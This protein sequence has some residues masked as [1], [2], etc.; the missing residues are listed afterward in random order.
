MQQPRGRGRADHR[1]PR[2]PQRRRAGDP[3]PP[4]ALRRH[5]LPGRARRARRSRSAPAS[6]TSPTRSTRCSRRAST[7]PARPRDEALAELRRAAGTQFCPRCVAR[8]RADPAA[9]DAAS[10][11][12]E[13]PRWP[14]SP[15]LSATGYAA[16]CAFCSSLN[17]LYHCWH[18]RQAAYRAVAEIDPEALAAFQAGI[19]KRYSDE[20]ILDELRACAER[21]GRSPTMQE[22]AADPETTVHPQ[23]VIEHFGSWNAAKRA[24]GLVRGGSR[25]AR[26]CS[27]CCASSARSWAA[28]PT[29]RDIDERRGRDAVEVALLAHVRL[30]RRTRCARRASTSPVG[31]ERLERAVEQGAALARRLGRLPKFADWAEAR[32]RDDR[33]PDRVAGLPDVRARRGAWSTFQFLSASAARARASHV[34]RRTGSGRASARPRRSR[35]AAGGRARPRAAR[36]RSAAGRSSTY[37]RSG[38][39]AR[40]ARRARPRARASC[41]RRARASQLHAGGSCSTIS[42]ATLRRGEEELRP[43]GRSRAAGRRRARGRRSGGARRATR[44]PSSRG[45][46][47]APRA[48]LSECSASAKIA[49]ESTVISGSARSKP[50]AA[51]SSSSLRMIPLWIPT[52]GAVPDR[53]VVRG[54]RRVALRVVADVDERLRRVGRD[55]SCVEERARAG[56]LLVHGDRRR[57]GRGAHSRPRRRRARRS[58]PAAPARRASGRRSTL[59][60]GYIRRFRTY[61]PRSLGWIP[62]GHCFPLDVSTALVR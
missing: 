2:V 9:R 54:D 21:L 1:P 57:P 14:P 25:R 28:S 5:R 26:S 3:P 50:C 40:S 35:R 37:E 47:R 39:N 20:Q 30:A 8:A 22:F 12:G 18:G 46:P 49:S 55:A 4:R 19:R 29:A 58:R 7:A 33:A 31:E 24:A 16:A 44:S 52:T 43:A 61:A 36:G 45:A 48:P 32:R 15:S 38:R 11:A 59:D 53:V 34:E 42:S 23:T 6:S 10:D 56:A 17:L 51:R 62:A 13:P 60:S 27:A 41:P